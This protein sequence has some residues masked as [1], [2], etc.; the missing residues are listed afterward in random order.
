[1]LYHFAPWTIF[2]IAVF[3]KYL[4]KK[5]KGNDFIYYSFLIFLFNILVY[6]LSPEVYARYLFMFYPLL[7]SILFYLFLQWLDETTWQHKTINRIFLSS[8]FLLALTFALLP[9]LN[10]AKDR[11]LISRNA[12]CWQ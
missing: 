3:Q 2:I 11:T 6:W 9:F 7:Y 12:F 5:I 8:V 1:M 4:W 10:V